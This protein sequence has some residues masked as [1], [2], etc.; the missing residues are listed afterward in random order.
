MRSASASLLVPTLLITAGCGDRETPG[1]PPRSAAEALRRV[2]DNFAR[3]PSGPALYTKARV[4]FEFRD[5]RGTHRFAGNDAVLFFRPPRM[6][7]FDVRSLT[8]TVAQIGSNQ[9]RYWVWIEPEMRTLWWG[10][11]ERAGREGARRLPVPPA[12]L[13]D[14]LALRPLPLKLNDSLTPPMLRVD[15]ADQRL[16]Y[17]RAEGGT[18]ATGWREVRLQTDR[19]YMPTQIIDR[20]ADGRVTMD[21]RLS[22]FRAVGSGGPLMARRYEMRWPQE[23]S[24]LALTIGGDARFR[25]GPELEDIFEFPAWDG[26]VES[27][28]APRSSR[29][30]ADTAA[31]VALG[32]DPLAAVLALET[33]RAA[34]PLGVEE[35]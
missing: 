16:L 14:A 30:T 12:D 11:W 3:F 32:V 35:P 29:R 1:V 23:G 21:A 18:T 17:I 22:E 2:N 10:S 9:E 7:R 28:D 31:D 6:L 15:G 34:H 4:S 19:P 25:T 20:L 27:I 8:G 26:A 24:Q 13:L 5:Q 33:L